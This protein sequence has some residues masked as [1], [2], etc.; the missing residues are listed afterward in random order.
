MNKGRHIVLLSAL[1][2]MALAGCATTGS[3]KRAQAAADQA[4]AR[5]DEGVTTAQRA[6]GSADSAAQ[7]AAQAQGSANNAM[8]AAQSAGSAAQAA[9]MAA[10]SAGSRAD[11]LE[12]R[13][14]SLERWKW[15]K[16]HPKKAKKHHARHHQAKHH[17]GLRRPVTADQTSAQKM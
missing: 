10:Q 7:A 9:S 4:Q 16:T 5:A 17:A 6:Q 13:L 2:P 3:V 1:L 15:A 12:T 11:S 14:R 8:T